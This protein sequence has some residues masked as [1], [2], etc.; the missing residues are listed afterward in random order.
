M[1]SK[2]VT[3]CQELG[4][5]VTTFQPPESPLNCPALLSGNCQLQS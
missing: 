3:M 1:M 5:H 2:H 4:K